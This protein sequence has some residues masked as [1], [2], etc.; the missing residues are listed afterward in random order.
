MSR[1]H[2]P[3]FFILLFNASVSAQFSA[4]K[5][6]NDPFTQ[7]IS[8]LKDSLGNKVYEESEVKEL[9]TITYYDWLEP[10]SIK[11]TYMFQKDGAQVGKYVSNAKQNKEDAEKT[12]NLLKRILTNKYGP[13][14]TETSLLGVTMLMWKS[15]K[16]STFML[17]RKGASAKLT[18]MK[19]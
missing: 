5:F 16:S 17:I 12:F 6:I 10:V 3:F 19:I 7:N 11:I 9:S 14:Y 2:N 18:V 4:E 1:I 8:S 13:S 15:D